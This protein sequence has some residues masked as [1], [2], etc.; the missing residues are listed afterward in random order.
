MAEGG[1]QRTPHRF[2]DLG[3]LKSRFGDQNYPVPEGVD[4]AAYGSVVVWCDTFKVQ[5]AVAALE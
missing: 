1:A 3:K 5:F 4:I 2:R